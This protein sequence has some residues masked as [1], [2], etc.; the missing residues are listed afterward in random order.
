MYARN[1]FL[2]NDYN[3]ILEKVKGLIFLHC[4]IRLGYACYQFPP[5][6]CES[7]ERLENA[8][9]FRPEAQ[10]QACSFHLSQ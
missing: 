6:R 8:F 3:D 4:Q 5:C 1:D 9:R 7:E 10:G 2:G